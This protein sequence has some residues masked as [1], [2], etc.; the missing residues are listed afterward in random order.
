MSLQEKAMLRWPDASMCVCVYGLF[1]PYNYSGL[2]CQVSRF[3]LPVSAVRGVHYLSSPI[4]ATAAYIKRRRD[5][6]R[7]L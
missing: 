7:N 6:T 4:Y 5:R 2:V 3:L 1:G